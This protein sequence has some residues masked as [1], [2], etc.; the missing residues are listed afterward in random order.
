MT[1]Q[2]ICKIITLTFLAFMIIY[3]VIFP[4]TEVKVWQVVVLLSVIFIDTIDDIGNS[5]SDEE[6]TI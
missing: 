6:N 5:K 1:Y 2:N 3:L 4:D